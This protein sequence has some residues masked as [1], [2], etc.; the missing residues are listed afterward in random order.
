MTQPINITL[1]PNCTSFATTVQEFPTITIQSFLIFLFTFFNRMLSEVKIYFRNTINM[2]LEQ[3]FYD[4]RFLGPELLRVSRH[5]E[6]ST[7]EN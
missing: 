7:I 2:T 5:T 4:F 3:T 6:K 1:V